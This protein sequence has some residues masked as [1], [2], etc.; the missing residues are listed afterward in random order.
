MEVGWP[1]SDLRLSDANRS[2]YRLAFEAIDT[3]V[4]HI[5]IE[6]LN[7]NTLPL[8]SV[9]WWCLFWGFVAYFHINGEFCIN[10]PVFSCI[11]DFNIFCYRVTRWW[12]NAGFCRVYLLY[13]S[14][15]GTVFS[16]SNSGFFDNIW[17][18][19][20]RFFL[21]FTSEMHR[22]F[23]IS[24]TKTKTIWLVFEIGFEVRLKFW[25]WVCPTSMKVKSCEFESKPCMYI[26]F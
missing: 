5:Y 24:S 18:F 2:E 9:V 17:C 7:L 8:F 14:T 15:R 23:S 20:L 11:W 4:W 13:E 19:S 1:E 25:F 10:G 3:S 26:F 16:K 21:S 22:R 12:W 6:I